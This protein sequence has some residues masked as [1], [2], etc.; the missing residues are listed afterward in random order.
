MLVGDPGATVSGEGR[1]GAVHV[2]KRDGTTWS[3][4]GALFDASPGGGARMGASISV[5]LVGRRPEPFVGSA[6]SGEVFVF[7]CSG[8]DGDVPRAPDALNP[9]RKLDDRCLEQAP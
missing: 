6:G 9:G 4:V 1:A 8:L 5:G 3:R 7:Y 2:F